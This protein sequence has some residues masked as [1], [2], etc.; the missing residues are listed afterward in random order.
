MT[1]FETGFVLRNEEAWERVIDGCGIIDT[2]NECGIAEITAKQLKEIGRR[3]PRLMAKVETRETMPEALRSNGLCILPVR[4]RGNYA[5][6]R[7][8][9]FIDIDYGDIPEN[10]LSVNRRFDMLD[11]FS[12]KKEPSLILTA[13]NYGILD[14][15]AGQRVC[16]T[17]FG[18]ESSDS[19]TFAIDGIDGES[20]TMEVDGSQMEMDGVF[21]SDDCVISIEA[22]MGTRGN[23]LARQLYYP[24]R[25]MEKRCSKPIINV[26]MTYSPGSIYLHTF[27]VDNPEKYNSFR[28][29]GRYRFD[30]FG[31][32]TAGELLSSVDDAPSPTEP[33][34]I[35]FPQ[36]DSMHKV[37]EALDIIRDDAGISDSDLGYRLSIEPRQGGYY[38]NACAYLGLV[39]RVRTG[40]WIRNNLSE[41]GR[42]LLSSD[43][44]TRIIMMVSLMS[45]RGVFR[46]FLPE[47][48]ETGSIPEKSEIAEWIR[49]NIT[50]MDASKRTPDRRAQTI[51]KWLE[52]VSDVCEYQ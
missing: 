48:L 12:I 9:A 44:R 36:A 41:A 23:F 38:G 22:K 21:E 1:E 40:R 3:E 13:F 19:F 42:R 7:F 31:K 43:M 49:R 35:P 24:Y 2:V 15:I 34:G 51:R 32:V 14:T 5:I 20:Y 4:S 46:R 29:T 18:R 27:A 37:F 25:M 50:S 8:D 28:N 45:R 11:P 6:G 16:M 39:D 30:L 33:Y 26:F 47:M 52:W 10:R 17:D